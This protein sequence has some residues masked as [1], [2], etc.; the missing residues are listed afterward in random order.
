MI[1]RRIVEQIVTC[2]GCG[3]E[4]KEMKEVKD[5]GTENE[6]TWGGL[7]E[8]TRLQ[9]MWPSY[10]TTCIGSEECK[11]KAIAKLTGVK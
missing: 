9:N 4:V 3:K 8:V 2:D 7:M 6:S 10:I 5:N 11:R 1:K